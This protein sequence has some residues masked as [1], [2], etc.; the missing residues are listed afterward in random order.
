MT[1]DTVAH[2]VGG[3]GLFLIGTEII[4]IGFTEAAGNSL[5]RILS[6]H[7][8]TTTKGVFAGFFVSSATQ[9]ATAVILTLITFVNAHILKLRQAVNI[10][11]GSN[12]GK[13]TTVWIIATL[14]LNI[15]LSA[16]ALPFIGIGVILRGF[17]KKHL[18]GYAYAVIG[19]ALMF[20]GINFLKNSVAG[21]T[22]IFALA[23]QG[24][25]PF[26]SNSLCLLFGMLITIIAQSST[27]PLAFTLSATLAHVVSVEHA[28]AIIIGL[29]LGTTSSAYIASFKLT[30]S[31]THRLAIAHIVFNLICTVVGLIFF[32]LLFHTELFSSIVEQIQKQP[33]SGLMLFYSSFIISSAL[34][35]LPA[36]PH[37]VSWLKDNFQ[38][39]NGLGTP[40]F[41][42][43]DHSASPHLASKAVHDEIVRFGQISSRMLLEAL[44]WNSKRGWVY[45]SDLSEEEFELDR[46]G[47]YIHRYVSKMTSA[48]HEQDF[49]NTMEFMIRATQHYELVSDYSDIICK[50]KNKLTEKI[51][52]KTLELMNDWS[53]GVSQ[54][55]CQIE[56]VIES[57]KTE[58]LKKII[59]EVKALNENR[60][61]LRYHLTQ[62]SMSGKMNSAQASHLIDVIENTRRSVRE[63]IKGTY[64]LWQHKIILIAN[65]DE[66]SNVTKL[67]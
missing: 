31:S 13:I 7:T 51:D 33:V 42:H 39:T 8:E 27:A 36:L 11:L 4:S 61:S 15:D 59:S 18:K 60:R 12:L 9:S 56:P 53:Q 67:N 38:K 58:D 16:Y 3:L 17:L 62:E 14:G 41:L 50:L 24:L 5:R 45:V 52:A 66:K 35:V 34:I 46:L 32:M 65:F 47:E 23:E 19:F 21:M 44:S 10:V 1:W 22:G 48:I 54:I 55:V 64:K 25:G 57:G 26:Q 37:F 20:L 63:M 43:Q 28:A 6:E 49:I 2:I 29:N 30:S 40:K